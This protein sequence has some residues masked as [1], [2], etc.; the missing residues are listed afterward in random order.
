M[1]RILFLSVMTVLFLTVSCTKVEQR[2]SFDGEHYETTF[3]YVFDNQWMSEN[4]GAGEDEIKELLLSLVAEA[5][6]EIECEMI[7]DGNELGFSFKLSENMEE[8]TEE[9][10]KKVGP[11]KGDGVL[12]IPF[13]YSQVVSEMLADSGNI[14]VSDLIPEL[15]KMHADRSLSVYV[16]K[17]VIETASSAELLGT[18]ETE[19]AALSVTDT[20]ESFRIDVPMNLLLNLQPYD[21]IVV[22]E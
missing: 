21:R 2:I 14:P 9:E 17:T 18:G 6:G 8:M 19:P 3:T 13:F 10:W 1:K 20:G 4:F 15:E 5:S 11:Q 16:D 7:N 22:R 12:T